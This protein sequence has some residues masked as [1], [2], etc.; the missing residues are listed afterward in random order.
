M[1]DVCFDKTR[2]RF[3]AIYI[4]PY[5]MVHIINRFLTWYYLCFGILIRLKVEQTLF[6][7]TIGF[8]MR[9]FRFTTGETLTDA[10]EQ[11]ISCHLHLE[12]SESIS[13][14]QEPNCSCYTEDDC[15]GKS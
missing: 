2:N 9:T 7:Q 11:T 10:Q 14:K 6:G 1:D 8:Q 13:E 3:R 4:Q 12:P 5:N 15:R